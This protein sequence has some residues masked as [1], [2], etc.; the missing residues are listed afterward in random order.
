MN[1]MIMAISAAAALA[2]S[3]NAADLVRKA[4]P[5]PAVLAE[6]KSSAWT[7]FYG[8]LNIG[9]GFDAAG[10]SHGGQTYYENASHDSQDTEWYGPGGPAWNLSAPLSGV[11]GGGQLG[12]NIEILPA[13]VVGLET[14]FQGAGLS[15]SASGFEATAI[16]LYPANI[17]GSPTYWPV[18]GTGTV[19]Q[20]VD[21]Y[22]T[23]RG[24]LG[25]TTFDDS[26]LVYATGG[27]AYGQVEQSLVYSGR[28]LPYPQLGFVGSHWEGFAATRTTR[29]GWTAGSGFEWF[30]SGQRRWSFKAEYLYTNLG[31][32]TVYQTAPAFKNTGEG[33]RTVKA[34]NAADLE[35]QSVRVGVNYHF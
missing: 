10:R 15:G 1:K 3:A 33:N 21:W 5:P 11:I 18:Q 19:S 29:V 16:A 27:L 6:P 23:F 7:G 12:Y 9:Y 13:I 26:L 4:A 24:R 17:P 14:D 32:S 20:K 35:W 25:V 2:P 22:G 8:G 30:P 34:I 31:A 28:F